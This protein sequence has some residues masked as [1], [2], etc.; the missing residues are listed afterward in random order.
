MTFPDWVWVFFPMILFI[1]IQTTSSQPISLGFKCTTP[2]KTCTSL[3]DY[4]LPNTTTLSSIQNLFQIKNLRTLLSANNL[5][6]TTP[7]NQ[8]FPS[9]QILKIPFPCLCQNNSGISNRRP[10]YTVVPNDGLY[11]IA[12]EVFSRLVTYQQI[13]QVNGIPDPNKI[14]VGAKL[15]VPLPCSCDDVDGESVVHCGYLVA[16]GN[17]VGG[18]AQRFNTTEKT[19][20]DLNGMSDA[21][22]LKADSIFDVPLKGKFYY[23]CYTEYFFTH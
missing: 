10:Y 21:K 12:A 22:D 20:L 16:S 23:Y 5:P 19:L 3:I 8:S 6:I 4:K 1:S 7:Q 9:S 18:I 15:W 11:H 14:E 2:N 13:Q 17:S